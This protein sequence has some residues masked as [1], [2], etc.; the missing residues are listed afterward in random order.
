MAPL[1]HADE[2]NRWIDGF[3]D[4]APR[5]GIGALRAMAEV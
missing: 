2:V 3:L 4:T 1:T 5:A